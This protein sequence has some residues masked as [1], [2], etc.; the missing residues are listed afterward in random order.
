MTHEN[1]V[2]QIPFLDEIRHGPDVI[3][4]GDAGPAYP[5]PVSGVG[6]RIYGVTGLAKAPR[7]WLPGP[8][9]GPA[10]TYIRIRCGYGSGKLRSAVETA[11]FA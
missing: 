1:D 8:S 6:G 9:A 11:S 4:V 2:A 10:K 5:R 3:I 7:G